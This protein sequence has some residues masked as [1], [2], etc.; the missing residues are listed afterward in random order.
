MDQEVRPGMIGYQEGSNWE[1]AFPEPSFQEPDDFSL[2]AAGGG[3][4]DQPS[5]GLP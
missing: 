1:F 5:Q 4:G 2:L 3:D